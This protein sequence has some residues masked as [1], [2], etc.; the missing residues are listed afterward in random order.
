MNTA[1]RLNN[2]FLIILCI[3]YFSDC[4]AVKDHN[5]AFVK[6]CFGVAAGAALLGAAALVSNYFT[7]PTDQEQLDSTVNQ[8]NVL[9]AKYAWA[10]DCFVDSFGIHHLSFYE[11][12][13]ILETCNE[14][15]LNH[16]AWTVWSNSK[17]V[18]FLPDTISQEAFSFDTCLRDLTSRLTVLK[19]KQY[20]SYTEVA[21]ID[22]ISNFLGTVS[23]SAELFILFADY[24]KRYSSYFGLS[25]TSWDL[26]NQ[27]EGELAIID[28]YR[29]DMYQL[30]AC[31]NDIIVNKNNAHCYGS[32]CRYPYIKYVES[33]D[34]GLIKLETVRNKCALLY[35]LR[36]AWIDSVLTPQLRWIR[37][38]LDPY[39]Q[40]ELLYRRRVQLDEEIV[41][42]RNKQ[43][44]NDIAQLELSRAQLD[45]EYGNVMRKLVIQIH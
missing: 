32:D 37:V 30:M 41:T 24:C 17:S 40:S 12:Q 9:R 2:V 26:Y 13:R 1:I 18:I 42:L 35:P 15:F 11:K 6:G 21:L 33:L 7:H 44:L 3:V 36:I 28:R 4:R 29:H 31:L 10:L 45:L 5:S 16:V 20:P 8:Y 19:A 43:A 39:Y 25:D 27:Y 38:T 23:Y 14:D 22:K 34:S